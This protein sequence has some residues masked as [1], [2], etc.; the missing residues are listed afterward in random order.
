MQVIPGIL[1]R[2]A[3]ELKEQ[4]ERVSWAKKVHIDI[5][6]G[7]FTPSKTITAMTLA[8]YLPNADIQIH[9]MAKK[10]HTYIHN[11][12]RMGATEIIIHA[13]TAHAEKVLADI[14][15]HGMKAGIALNPETAP[16][17]HKKAIKEANFA[18]VMTVH[19]GYAG[20]MFLKTPLSKITNLSAINSRL[21]V[22]VD[23]G[24]NLQTIKQAKT[25]GAQFAIATS[26]CTLAKDPRQAWKALKK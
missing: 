18:L 23:G 20:Q 4:L 3:K 7:K 13:E 2:T 1:A 5:M 12:S 19:P 8:K 6:D 24:I 21:R 16:E 26:A 9:L 15:Q 11:F 22:G 25:A 17:H 14:K 10:P